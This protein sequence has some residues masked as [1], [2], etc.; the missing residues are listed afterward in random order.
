MR[1]LGIGL[2]DRVRVLCDLLSPITT[3]IYTYYL[4]LATCYLLLIANTDY[5]YYLLP[6]RSN[7]QAR[8]ALCSP[9]DL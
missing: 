8:C 2:E 7:R 5:L 6:L 9:P 1:R 3:Y 4:L